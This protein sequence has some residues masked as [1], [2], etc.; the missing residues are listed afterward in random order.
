MHLNSTGYGK[1]AINLI[2]KIKTLS[3]YWL[4]FDSVCYRPNVCEKFYKITNFDRGKIGVKSI[5]VV[6]PL[7][8]GS[9][10]IIYVFLIA[11]G[12]MM[13]T[14]GN[15]KTWFGSSAHFTLACYC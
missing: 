10:A 11:L 7:N 1:L 12:W 5:I 15:R 3:K 6:S 4:Y 2:E 13:P 9:Q 8:V 14:I